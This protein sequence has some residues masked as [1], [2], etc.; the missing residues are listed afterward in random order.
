MHLST[1]GKGS[2]AHNADGS[3]SINP[4]PTPKFGTQNHSEQLLS[5]R[6]R[7]GV[8][9][10]GAHTHVTAARRVST[11]FGSGKESEASVGR[12]DQFLAGKTYEQNEREISQVSETSGKAT[13]LKRPTRDS[14]VCFS[15]AFTGTHN[16]CVK[17]VPGK[18]EAEVKGDGSKSSATSKGFTYPAEFTPTRCLS[19]LQ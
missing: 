12:G 4:A 10:G 18:A 7:P 1:Q 5:S 6:N 14:P 3:G 19:L 2:A 9:A 13:Y 17:N 8:S 16:D 11:H 15:Q